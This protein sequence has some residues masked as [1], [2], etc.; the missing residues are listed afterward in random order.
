M[1][2][3]NLAVPGNNLATP[4]ATEA[5]QDQTDFANIINS[6]PAVAIEVQELNQDSQQLAAVAENPAV[7]PE[8]VEKKEEEMESGA[9]DVAAKM[10][11]NPETKEKVMNK[12]VDITPKSDEEA[13]KILLKFDPT[14][15]ARLPFGKQYFLRKLT[16][17]LN[18]LEAEKE[19]GLLSETKI[20]ILAKLQETAAIVQRAIDNSI[21]NRLK[22]SFGNFTSS[23]R[24]MKMPWRKGGKTKKRR[25]LK[26]TRGGDPVTDFFGFLFCIIGGVF[27]G[28]FG[29]ISYL[30]SGFIEGIMNFVSLISYLFNNLPRVPSLPSLPRAPS[31]PSEV[32]MG[33]GALNAYTQARIANSWLPFQGRSNNKYKQAA[34]IQSMSAGKRRSK[35]NKRKSAKRTRT[36]KK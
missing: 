28:G 27:S 29:A 15:V 13:E 21:S 23:V 31:L 1:D 32:G 11:A 2:N 4:D 14:F 35:R 9:E 20:K 34:A 17:I 30:G 25:K 36:H 6:D 19:K 8:V 26:K 22:R 7:S 16:P 18:A 5:Q 24:N 10:M 12:I 33:I 3:N